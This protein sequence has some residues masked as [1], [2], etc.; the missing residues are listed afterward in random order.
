MFILCTSGAIPIRW[1]AEGSLLVPSSVT[2]AGLGSSLAS[3]ATW[4]HSGCLGQFKWMLP[5]S[6]PTLQKP[7]DL[8]GF[9]LIL[10]GWSLAEAVAGSLWRLR[11]ALG[12]AACRLDRGWLAAL[13]GCL[14]V[15]GR[16]P[17]RRDPSFCEPNTTITSGL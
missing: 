12:S 9:S 6:G 7:I 3:F 15:A 10:E 16:P 17:C 4:C 1:G 8:N 13:M 11:C 2:L 5:A 14:L